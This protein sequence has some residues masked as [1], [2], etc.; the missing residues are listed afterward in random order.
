[1][2]QGRPSPDDDAPAAR[3]TIPDSAPVADDSIGYTI[4]EL[5][6][7]S[8]VPAR[9]IRFYRQSGLIDPPT[10]VGRNAYYASDQ[11]VRLQMVA[12]L[13]EQGL[14]LD[15][16]ARVLVNQQGERDSLTQILRLGDELRTPWIEDGEAIL[17]ER[18]VLDTLGIDNPRSI[19]VLEANG[20][21]VRLPK[22][23]PAR[24]H[25]QSVG[26]L[27]LAGQLAAIGVTEQLAFESWALIRRR[28]AV[29][30]RDL[31]QLYASHPRDGL[32]GWPTPETVGEAFNAMKPVALRAVE[33][34]FAQEMEIA[35]DEWVGVGGI[36]DSEKLSDAEDGR[37]RDRDGDRGADGA[38]QGAPGADGE[39][40][41]Y[42][43]AT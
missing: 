17:S 11:L 14:G 12:G 39:S 38:P 40:A 43:R 24:W 4:E 5:E 27:Q 30:A 18:E 32:P 23:R 41:Q 19:A 34:G 7:A 33:L 20:V 15:A 9:T 21:I 31:V 37:D 2:P 3:T 28:L 6:A 25:V 16:I 8:G 22:S 13:R 1:M 35:V 36:F 10:R 42:D 26:Q 29:L